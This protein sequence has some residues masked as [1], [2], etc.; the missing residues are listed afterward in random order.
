[1]IN[2]WNTNTWPYRNCSPST[3]SQ[4]P[5]WGVS[6]IL[7]WPMLGHSVPP[8][9]SCMCKSDEPVPLQLLTTF[10]G[11]GWKCTA[12][13]VEAISSVMNGHDLHTQGAWRV[14]SRLGC[15]SPPPSEPRGFKEVGWSSVAREHQVNLDACL[16]ILIHLVQ[17]VSK[18]H[19]SNVSPH[20][21]QEVWYP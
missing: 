7:K 15:W 16:Q 18:D 1:M 10:P 5:L 14:R 3:I 13:H 8:A 19:V 21:S 20:V 6:G 2:G 11:K 4:S 17:T 9:S 12:S